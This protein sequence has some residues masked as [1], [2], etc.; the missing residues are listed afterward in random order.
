[1]F[2]LCVGSLP[3]SKISFFLLSIFVE[4]LISTQKIIIFLPNPIPGNEKLLCLLNPIPYP[5]PEYLY[6]SI[7]TFLVKLS[8]PNKHFSSIGKSLILML[9]FI[10]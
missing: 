2:Y 1:M 8:A 7:S 6:L 10:P 5:Y 9:L 4:E 3:K